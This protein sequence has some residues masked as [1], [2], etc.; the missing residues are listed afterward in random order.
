VRK[1]IVGVLARGCD[2]MYLIAVPSTKEKALERVRFLLELATRATTPLEEAR[3]AA[4]EACRSIARHGLVVVD[5][6]VEEVRHDEEFRKAVERVVEE[7]IAEMR[8]ERLTEAERELGR[9]AARGAGKAA[10]KLAEEGIS[11]LFG[12]RRR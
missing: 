2:R 9:V 5:R 7:R 1:K 8:S 3:S 6:V 10:E 4:L 12:K 11:W